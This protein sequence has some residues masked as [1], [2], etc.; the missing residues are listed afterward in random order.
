V[1]REVAAPARAAVAPEDNDMTTGAERG[2]LAAV[3]P[4]VRQRATDA[5]QVLA[6]TTYGTDWAGGTAEGFYSESDVSIEYVTAGG[7]QK[8]L[9]VAGESMESL[10]RFVMDAWPT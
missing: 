5:V 2:F 6:V 8:T 9:T 10:W 1:G 3:L 7:V 4:W